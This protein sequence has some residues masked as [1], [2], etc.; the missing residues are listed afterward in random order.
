MTA[1]GVVRYAQILDSLDRM[2][3][4]AEGLDVCQ[5]R[6]RRV[7]CFSLDRWGQS[8]KE[9]G[10]TVGDGGQWPETQSFPELPRLL[11]ES[12]K[13]LEKFRALLG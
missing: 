3:E 9:V 8:P 11:W 1:L 4:S 2:T 6:K 12:G 10:K 7:W 13:T 5:E